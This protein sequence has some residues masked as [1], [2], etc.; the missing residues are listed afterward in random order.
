MKSRIALIIFFTSMHTAA[1]GQ[2]PVN[3]SGTKQIPPESIEGLRMTFQDYVCYQTIFLFWAGGKYTSVAMALPTCHSYLEMH[4]EA[5]SF[6]WRVTDERH[7]YLSFGP[8]G[9]KRRVYKFV[10]DTPSTATG[11]LAEDVRPYTFN[12]DKP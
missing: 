7:A 1:F 3:T 5:G 9:H 6:E 8:T 11:Y 10:F 2:A 4:T 12:F